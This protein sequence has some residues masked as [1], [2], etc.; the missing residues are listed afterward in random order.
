MV[1]MGYV[2]MKNG[3]IRQLLWHHGKED[4]L[5]QRSGAGP[6]K[7]SQTLFKVRKILRMILSVTVF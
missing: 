1:T 7:M 2:I 4:I 5:R 3:R 6:L